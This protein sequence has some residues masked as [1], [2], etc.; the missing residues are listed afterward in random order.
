MTDTQAAVP[1]RRNTDF[2]L[3]WSGAALS[4]FGS[5]L[6]MTAYPLLV[7]AVTGSPGWAGAVAAAQQLPNL[8]VQVPAGVVVDRWN[9]KTT[10][11]VC[12]LVRAAALASIPV[13]LLT[14][15][16]HV[17]HLL[18]VAFVEGSCTVAYRL[19]EAGAIRNVVASEQYERALAANQV[20]TFGAALLGRPAAGVLFGVSRAL[21]FAVDALTYLL[22]LV[23]TALTRG[24]FQVAT[25]TTVARRF[26]REA[27]DGFGWLWRRPYLR[28]L[29]LMVSVA[30]LVLQVLPLVVIVIAAERG[31]AP[32]LIGVVLLGFAIGGLA[33]SLVAAPIRARVSVRTVVLGAPWLWFACCAV[34]A[35]YPTPVVLLLAMV[36]VGFGNAAWNVVVEAY[37]L[38]VVPD[39]LIGRVGATMRLLAQGGAVV[40]PLAVGLVLERT[41]GVGGMVATTATVLALAVT[42]VASPVLRGQAP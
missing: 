41:G 36:G 29:N 8:L 19:A 12:D 39:E 22:S 27:V 23:A 24:R 16:T 13:A 1:L 25:S 34:A 28:A 7:L 35:A 42:A 20:R 2:H 38:R 33:G 17:A 10:M 6:S 32:A 11:I 37:S 40:G 26:W 30:T 18:V 21:P 5:M 31:V 4:Q 14:T 3:L 15:G 9:R